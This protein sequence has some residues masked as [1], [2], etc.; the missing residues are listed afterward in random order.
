MQAA[1]GLPIIVSIIALGFGAPQAYSDHKPDSNKNFQTPQ[2]KSTEFLTDGAL[3][4]SNN[5]RHLSH[6]SVEYQGRDVCGARYSYGGA[7]VLQGYETSRKFQ[8]KRYTNFMGSH[9]GKKTGW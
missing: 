1:R 5:N 4:H 7:A 3:E 2:L 6:S 8:G 9:P